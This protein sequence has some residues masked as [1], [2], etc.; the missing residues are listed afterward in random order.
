[1]SGDDRARFCADCKLHVY[2]LSAMSREE[3]LDLISRTEGR[4]CIRLYRRPDGTVLTRDCPVGLRAVRLRT[5]RAARRVAAAIALLLTGG[6][7]FGAGGPGSARL[8][9]IRPFSVICD[10]I[11]P[12][13]AP[14]P[15]TG[16]IILG[17]MCVLPTSAPATP[18][19]AR[20][21]TPA[22]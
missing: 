15:P 17:A 12:R 21:G 6:L 13:A 18:A 4:L 11:A 8:R 20:T 14:L 9:Q 10:W 19:P 1:M 22:P 2:N 7:V 5:A 16:R 3:A